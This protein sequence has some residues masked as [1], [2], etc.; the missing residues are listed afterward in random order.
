ML[1]LLV[2]ESIVQFSNVPNGSTLNIGSTTTNGAMVLVDPD[3]TAN[4]CW[5]ANHGLT[6]GDL[7]KFGSSSTSVPSG[8]SRNQYY[9]VYPVNANR[10]KFQ[11]YNATTIREL[12]SQGSTSATIEISNNVPKAEQ[13]LI[14]AQQSITPS[15]TT[16]TYVVSVAAKSGGG[17]NAYYIDGNEAPALSLTEGNTY[18]F[19]QASASNYGHLLRFSTTADGTHGSGGV[20]YTTGVTEVGTPGNAGAYTQIVVASGAPALYY[21]CINHAGMG[22]FGYSCAII[23]NKWT[24]IRCRRQR[25]LH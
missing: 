24:W 4:T 1:E 14:N 2:G 9:V 25:C 19:D 16:T 8:L 15:P 10:I 6:Q 23:N 11:Q 5:F 18:I 21:Y 22:N 17:G 12:T 7:V 3:P 13:D 20:A